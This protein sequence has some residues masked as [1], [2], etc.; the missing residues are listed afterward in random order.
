MDAAK[1]VAAA[2]DRVDFCFLGG[3][4][5]AA[6]ISQRTMDEQLSYVHFFPKVSV[7][8]VGSYLATAECLLFNLHPD[9]L[10][11]ITIP[12]RPQAYMKVGRPIIIAGAGDAATLIE[13]AKAGIA[14]PPDDARPLA[15]AVLKMAL[16]GHDTR[17]A[18]ANAACDHYETHLSLRCRINAFDTLFRAILRANR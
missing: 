6:L 8:K 5:E 4:L 14:V 16:L 3:G 12:S 13:E 15:A 1:I 17:A 11:E 9:P 18:M 2:N 10:F 7:A